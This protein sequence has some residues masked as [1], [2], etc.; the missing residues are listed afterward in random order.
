MKN[1]I[2]GGADNSTGRRRAF[3]AMLDYFQML[4]LLLHGTDPAGK[5]H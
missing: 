5:K 2:S 3:V 1:R 4:D